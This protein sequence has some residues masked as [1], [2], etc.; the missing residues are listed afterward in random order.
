MTTEMQ[1]PIS[2]YAMGDVLLDLEGDHGGL[3]HARPLLAQADIVV[4]NCEGVCYLAEELAKATF[5][6]N[7]AETSPGNSDIT[8][9]PGYVA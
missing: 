5:Y 6:T 9:A 4:G 2:I 3:K 8:A 7:P 1:G